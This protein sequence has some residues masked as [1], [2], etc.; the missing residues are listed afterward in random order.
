MKW[1]N[2]KE[3]L[4]H[5]LFFL[6]ACVSI[7]AVVLICVFLFANGIPA[8]GKIGVF[9]FLLGT[10]WKP[11][12]DIYGILPM[13]LGSLYVTAGNH[14]RCADWTSDGGFSRKVLPEGSL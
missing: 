9:K 3:L 5:I 4:M 1:S 12:N 11:G 7:F 8:I 10:K 2:I 13:I 14:H 6:T